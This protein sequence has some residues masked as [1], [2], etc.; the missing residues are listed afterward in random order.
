[1]L[2]I[3]PF[4]SSHVDNAMIKKI[5]ILQVGD[6]HY[7]DNSSDF[8]A[9]EFKDQSFPDF[10]GAG[11]RGS[12]IQASLRSVAR[13][14]LAR[15]I[16]AVCFMGDLTDRGDVT[17]FVN[18][19]EKMHQVFV[20]S[21]L[22]ESRSAKCLIV[23]GNHDLTRMLSEKDDPNLRFEA[24]NKILVERGHQPILINEPRFISVSNSLK[25]SICGLNTCFGCGTRRNVPALIGDAI[26]KTLDEQLGRGDLSPDERKRILNEIY[27]LDTPA[28]HQEA[29]EKI[30]SWISDLD[31]QS[32]AIVCGHHN[33]I[34]QKV[35]RISPY[36]EL[37]NSGMF[38]SEILS[39]NRPLIY[40]HGHIHDDPID[41]LK[42]ADHSKCMIAL[43]SAPLF[44][45]GYNIVTIEFDGDGVPL[46][47]VVEKFRTTQSGVCSSA[48]VTSI[49]FW[50][51][52]L[53]AFGALDELALLVRDYIVENRSCYFYDIVKKFRY[54]EQELQITLSKLQWLGY[55]NIEHH[56]LVPSRWIVRRQ[57]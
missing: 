7:P 3:R 14:V 39:L 24:I 46:G 33:I 1:M 55:V 32:V 52:A 18:C 8:T 15:D 26:M 53:S 5:S 44:A 16:Q 49:P 27:S 41:I 11:L 45:D 54:S 30:S 10:L 42:S 19:L 29:I 57:Q 21:L 25:I 28:I 22:S 2:P 20:D 31:E 35:P 50:R 56:N 34:P 12:K 40:M 13:E 37:V 6:I 43:V 51:D 23:P 38:R 36:T 9:I 47:A 4:V 17:G 48:G